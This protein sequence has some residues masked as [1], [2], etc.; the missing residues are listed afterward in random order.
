MNWQKQ[1]EDMMQTWTETQ[2]KM[3][4]GWAEAL[5]GNG[6]GV[7]PSNEMWLKTL[8]TWQGMVNNGLDTQTQWAT[9]W[10]DNVVKIEGVPAPTLEWAKQAQEVNTRWS[11]LQKEMWEKWFEFVKKIEPGKMPPVSQE[12]F[13]TMFQTW[14]QATQEIIKMQTDWLNSTATAAQAQVAEVT[15]K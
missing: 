14:Q 13:Q 10:S 5:K 8:D 4:D 2:K 1:M 3:W 12:E 9:M 6:I 11:G 7:A 15:K